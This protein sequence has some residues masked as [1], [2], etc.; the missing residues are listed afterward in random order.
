M[1]Y[2]LRVDSRYRLSLESSPAIS[3]DDV[4]CSILDIR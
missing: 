4:E 2:G 3:P 1:K